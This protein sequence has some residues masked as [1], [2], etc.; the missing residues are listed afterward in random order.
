MA[1]GRHGHA[2]A[3]GRQ[4]DAGGSG[5]ALVPACVKAL[6]REGVAYRSLRGEKTYIDTLAVWRKADDSPL[7]RALLG[8]L[9]TLDSV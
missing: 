4:A 5:V 2:P 9:P 3:Q 7:V 1:G 8:L 6:H